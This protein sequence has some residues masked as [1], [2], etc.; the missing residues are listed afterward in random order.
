MKGSRQKSPGTVIRVD[1]MDESNTN[2]IT[3]EQD[4]FVPNIHLPTDDDGVCILILKSL[5]SFNFYIY[6]LLIFLFLDKY[7]YWLY[8]IS[9]FNN[10]NVFIIFKIIVKILKLM[11]LIL[12][13]IIYYNSMIVYAYIKLLI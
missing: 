11:K 3:A 7:F 12:L 6:V 8:I 10:K 4:E 5:K 2:L 1:A 13:L 9:F